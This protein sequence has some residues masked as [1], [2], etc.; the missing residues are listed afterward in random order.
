[1]TMHEYSSDTSDRRLA[2][3]IIAVIAVMIAYLYQLTASYLNFNLPWWVE[4]PSIM[5]V[6]GIMYY[7]YD[8]RFWKLRVFGFR[9]SYIPD[10]SGTWYGE[11]ES[12]FSGGSKICGMLQIHQTW[13]K[14]SIRLKTTTSESFSRMA[15]FNIELGPS[16]GLV[17]EYTSDPRA[18][19]AATM[20]AHRGFAFLKIST[21]GEWL[22]G[23]YYTGRDRDNQGTMRFRLVSQEIID[24]SHA[25]EKYKRMKD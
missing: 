5:L 15:S 18:N 9:F 2:V 10:C 16:Q 12:T 21:D 25:Q 11:I 8:R 1:M 7:F 24:L 20:H 6:Y 17:Y 22:D 4:S 14:I 23:D 19:T 3:W 13:S